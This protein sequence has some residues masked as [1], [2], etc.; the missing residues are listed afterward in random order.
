MENNA[1]IPNAKI[2][3]LIA[4]TALGVLRTTYFATS[5]LFNSGNVV[6]IYLVS[7]RGTEYR[8]MSQ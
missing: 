2:P 7:D 1:V 6:R 5:I 4:V 3:M 8:G